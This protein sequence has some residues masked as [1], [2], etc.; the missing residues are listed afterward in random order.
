VLQAAVFS[1]AESVFGHSPDEIFRVEVVGELVAV[2]QRLE[3]QC[4]RLE[5]LV[6]RI[7]DLLPGPPPSRASLAERLDEPARLLWVELA[8]RRKA[9][10][11][12]EVLLDNVDGLSSLAASLS[13][14]VVLLLE[15]RIDTATANGV[16]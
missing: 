15:D 6:T 12:L 13:M 5:Q 10:T 14:V 1:T 9:D 2:F 16:H 7:C 3:E 11:E 8:A 4:S